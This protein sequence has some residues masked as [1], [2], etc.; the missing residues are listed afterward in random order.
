MR[1][2]HS[3]TFSL[4]AGLYWP[5]QGNYISGYRSRHPVSCMPRARNFSRSHLSSLWCLATVY[6]YRSYQEDP[7]LTDAISIWENVRRWR[8]SS[9]DVNSGVHSASNTT[10]RPS[11]D[12]RQY[13][14]SL[15]K[16]TPL[17]LFSVSTIGGLLEVMHHLSTICWRYLTQWSLVRCGSWNTVFCFYQFHETR[18]RI[19]MI[20]YFKME[21]V[22]SVYK[23]HT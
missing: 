11:C 15:L 17:T 12:N 23:A 14:Y 5:D 22:D 19:V 3:Y 9:E 6:L 2:V 10:I 20:I 13:Y 1:T 16:R 21:S 4:I 8:V 7:L 18:V